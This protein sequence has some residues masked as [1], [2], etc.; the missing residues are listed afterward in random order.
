MNNPTL[1]RAEFVEY[2]A[3]CFGLGAAAAGSKA[4]FLTELT[5]KVLDRHREGL[6]TGLLVDEAQSL[7]AE[8]LEEIRLLANIET[9]SEKV[10]PVVLAGQAELADRLNEPNLRQIKQRIS[11]RCTLGPLDL[12]EVAGYIAGRIEI[13]GGTDQH[14]FTKDAIKAIYDGSRGIPRLINV[15]CDN[16]LLAGFAANRKPITRDLVDEVCRDFDLAPAAMRLTPEPEP[17]RVP[18]VAKS[19]SGRGAV[20]TFLRQAAVLFLLIQTVIS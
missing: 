1:T 9:P 3:G 20:R 11:L 14:L 10:F 18:A 8:L 7:S 19:S 16:V 5:A 2:L 12:R 15:I 4:K 17:A 13:A 6:V